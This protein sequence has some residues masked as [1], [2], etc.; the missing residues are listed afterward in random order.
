VKAP[1]TGGPVRILRPPS[2]PGWVAIVVERR[3]GT[4]CLWVAIDEAALLVE[5]LR[6]VLPPVRT[7]VAAPPRPGPSQTRPSAPRPSSPMME[8]VSHDTYQRR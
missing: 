4:R 8:D 3:R 5:L 6:A 7:A 2:R 1:E